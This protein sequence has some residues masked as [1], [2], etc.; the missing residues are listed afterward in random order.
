M[1]RQN[2]AMFWRGAG[3]RG[4]QDCESELTNL[5]NSMKKRVLD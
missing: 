4:A 5:V 3:F 2:I 1:Q